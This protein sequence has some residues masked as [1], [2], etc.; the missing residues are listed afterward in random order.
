MTTPLR[1]IFDELWNGKN[2][3][4]IDE[5]MSPEYIHHDV[6]YPDS[7]IDG[8]KQFVEQYLTAFPDIRITIH[9]EIVAGDAI[10]ARWTATGTQNGDLLKLPPTGNRLSVTGIT[11]ARVMDGKIVE[12]WNNWD[13]LGMMR[14][15]GAIPRDAINRAA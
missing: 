7:G 4:V 2:R 6:L 13:A 3:A 5:V 11:I 12:S 10:V 14:Q 9:D 15:L 1:R 8:Y